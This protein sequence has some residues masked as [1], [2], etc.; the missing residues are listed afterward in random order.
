MYFTKVQKIKSKEFKTKYTKLI[1]FNLKQ[2]FI[3]NLIVL[4]F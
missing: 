1:D 4:N 3:N 2:F